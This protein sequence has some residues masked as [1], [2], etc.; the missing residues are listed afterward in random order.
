MFKRNL[1]KAECFAS[2]PDLAFVVSSRKCHRF[3]FS[4]CEWWK[5]VRRRGV[6]ISRL[7][8]DPSFSAGR[9]TTVTEHNK[10]EH[11]TYPSFSVL[12]SADLAAN[13]F[14]EMG[15]ETA[16]LFDAVASCLL[17]DGNHDK[18]RR[19]RTTTQELGNTFVPMVRTAIRSRAL[20]ERM[21]LIVVLKIW[22]IN[23]EF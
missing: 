11:G 3:A 17:D 12:I 23:L 6:S 18:N 15:V 21:R 9:A 14:D 20:E 16:G 4:V 7:V 2:N 8:P 13:V 10:T 22:Q 19:M 1:Q 5:T